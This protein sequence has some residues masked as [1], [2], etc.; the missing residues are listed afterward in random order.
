VADALRLLSR[1]LLD[2]ASLF[3]WQ[4]AP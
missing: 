1:E 2:I 3:S 4:L